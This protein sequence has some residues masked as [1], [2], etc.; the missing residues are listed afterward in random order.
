MKRILTIDI[1]G[2]YIKYGQIQEDLTISNKGRKATPDSSLED[3]LSVL[4]S[5]VDERLPLDGIAISMPGFIN[6][7]TGIAHTAGALHYMKEFPL[8][9]VLEQRYGIP[10]SL[11]NDAKAAMLAEMEYGNLKD[12]NNGI[13]VILGTAVG[14]GIMIN[15][16][17]IKGS[18]LT[19]GE[20]SFMRFDYGDMSLERGIG[21]YFGAKR[22]IRIADAKSSS[23][24]QNG[25]EIFDAI[26]AGDTEVL[27]VMQT[28]CRQ[29]CYMIYNLHAAIDTDQVV[30][31]GGISDEPLFLSLLKE[32]MDTYYDDLPEH[33]SKPIIAP[34]YFKSE[35][36]LIGAYCA[37][38]LK[39]E[40]ACL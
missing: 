13:A 17:L 29:L 24:I 33:I 38:R 6:V 10:V 28:F 32:A 15:R 2:S 35:A 11:E 37:Y 8:Q 22:L 21:Y 5:I 26:K 27:S 3:F 34:T 25:V 14:G 39:Y 40:G 18:H 23:S 36:N 20:F 12:A 4:S 16:Q 9:K 19:S 1:G 30:V 7:D 31:G